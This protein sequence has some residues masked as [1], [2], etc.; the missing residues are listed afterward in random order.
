MCKT[1]PKHKNIV[2][3]MD[4]YSTA[5]NF[6]VMMEKC[7]GDLKSVLKMKRTMTEEEVV[8]VLLDLIEA[9]KH[10]AVNGYAHCN[11]KPSNV[12]VT[13]DGVKKLIDFGLAHKISSTTKTTF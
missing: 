11:I 5:N 10:L 3:V 9:M 4:T 12:L 1:I 6:Y 8:N 7:S 2:N 13:A